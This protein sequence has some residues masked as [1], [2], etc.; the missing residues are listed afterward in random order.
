MEEMAPLTSDELRIYEL[1]YLRPPSSRLT[2]SLMSFLSHPI[3][4][5]RTV[6]ATKSSYS[7]SSEA[8]KVD[9]ESIRSSEA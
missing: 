6:R 9:R 1:A 2:F 3:A 4:P 8:V 5:A 7:I